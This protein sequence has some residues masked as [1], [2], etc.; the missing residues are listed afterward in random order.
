M[1]H[2]E[3]THHD[4]NGKDWKMASSA[5]LHCLTGC[6][7][8]EILGLMIGVGLGLST[9]VTIG[10][11]V[12]LAFLFG[13]SLS[14]LPLLRAGLGGGEAL[15][16]VFAADTLSIASME[17]TDNGI[18][19]MIPGAMDSGLGNPLF[20][21]SMAVALAIAFLVALPVNAF[22]LARNKGHALTHKYHCAHGAEG[23][24]KHI[25]N[26]SS[27]MLAVALAAFMFGGFM[28]SIY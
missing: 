3:H 24:R 7:M 17:L 16:I 2:T 27:T 13:Y 1:E 19:A 14:I 23:W 8:G 11:A 28:G 5:T 10:L 22:L 20:W 6:A 26:P 12:T 21:A 25:P 15:S 4:S 18:M 9:L